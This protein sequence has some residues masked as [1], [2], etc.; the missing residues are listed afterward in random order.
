MSLPGADPHTHPVE[1]VA[2]LDNAR[3]D[4]LLSD[5][6]LVSKIRHELTALDE[7][8]ADTPQPRIAYLSPEF[9]IT[10]LIPQYA[11][12]L[13]VLAGD[14]LKAASDMGLDIA[15]VGLLYRQGVFRQVIEG[16]SQR[17]TY[18]VVDPN[19]IGATDTGVV[20]EVPFPG[21]EVS[22]RVWRLD[23]GRTPLL[24]LDTNL[25]TNSA[26]D[27][28]I[29]DSLYQ[30]FTTHRVDQEM[31]LGVGGG[32]ALAAMEWPVAVHHLNE[33]HAGFVI[34]ELIDRVIE[35]GDIVAAIDQVRPGLIFTTHTPVP[36][37]IDRFSTETIGPYLEIWSERW[38]APSED[39][40]RLGA[41]PEDP[42]KFNM[43][44]M[45][46]RVAAA[47]NGVSELHGE[48]SRSLFAGV[49]IGGD[50]GAVT[51]GVHAR[52]WTAPHLQG[53]FDDRLGTGWA[54]GDAESWERA[55]E[56]DKAA[57]EG[58]RRQ[59]S[60]ALAEMVRAR[61]G[62][63]VDPDSLIIGFARRFAPYKRATL[64]MRHRD[65]L[66]MLLE[67]DQ[68][69]VH[70][71]FAGKA[72]PAD[73]LGKQLVSDLLSFAGSKE[74]RG[75]LTFI[76][77]YD[78]DIAA[79]LVQGCD[80]WLNNPIRP[81]EA[82]GTSGEKAALN[83]GLNCSI[84]DG[85]WAEMFDGENGWAI[86]MSG[87]EDHEIRDDEEASAMLDVLTVVCAEYHAARTVFNGRIRHAWK[88][89][90]PRVTAARMLREYRDRL[91][92]PALERS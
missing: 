16:N 23:V 58:A 42:G 4:Q 38:G 1:V 82:S 22:A 30:G 20:I 2:H 79:G 61:A 41:D 11:G 29:T 8:L 87:H 88:T 66:D 40:W 54:D 24:L 65:R 32:R 62:A 10:A 64:L 63:E 84:L 5:D 55:V 85:W 89:L 81:R 74:S 14:H 78:M 91:Y 51:N 73:D 25:E 34:L 15:G 33:G 59:S 3:L 48:V 26:D 56:I 45:S 39:L 49:G 13:G 83:G 68:R 86:P 75:R 27:R 31:I 77:D 70:F 28:A 53:L 44:A 67:D 46:L 21:R 71:L 90:G 72:H 37:G 50:I 35:D 17:E 52:T 57:L 60:L 80:I 76:A 6:E 43:A 9:G 36:A 18:E 47:A 7:L 69:P 19:N 12:G 92:N